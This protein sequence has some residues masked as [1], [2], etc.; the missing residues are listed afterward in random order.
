M[1]GS[2]LLVNRAPVL[3]LWARLVAERLGHP[4]A[5]A[6]TL[7]KAVAGLNAQS[8]GRRLGINE[9]PA[10]QAA[11]GKPSASSGGPEASIAL[12]G[13]EEPVDIRRGLTETLTLLDSKVRKKSVEVSLLPPA[14]L[15]FVQ[16]V[17][18][19]LNQVWMNLI[20]NALDAAPVGGHVT[21]DAVRERDRVIV[22]IMDDGHGI[23]AE[24]QGRIFDPFFTTKGVGQGT[25]LGLDIVRRLLKQHEG[26]IAL[27]SVPGRTEFQVRLLLA[28]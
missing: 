9:E 24:I 25:G 5:T 8:K 22:R 6:L 15:P 20:D 3:T 14:D 27:E 19:E 2:P 26:D 28:K 7:G 11:K 17:G 18:A 12:L 1:A 13:R 21:V 4:R 10:K 23:P 16:G